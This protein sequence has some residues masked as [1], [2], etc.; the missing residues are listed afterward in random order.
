[1]PSEIGIDIGSYKTV[2][3]SSSSVL[4]EQP[5]VAAVDT[6]TLEPICFGDK[7]YAM[8]DKTPPSIEIVRPIV[9]GVVADYA[10]TEKMLKFFMAEAFSNNIIK[11]KIMVAMPFGVTSVQHR[12]VAKALELSGGRDVRT[13]EAPLADAIALKLNFENPHGYFLIDIG[14][15]TTDIAA[16]SMGG[17]VKSDTVP[18]A[19]FDFDDAIIKYVRK[20]FSV[21]IGHLTAETIKKQIGGAMPRDVSLTMTAS[22]MENFSRKP[23]TFEITSDDI[24]EALSEPLKA[25][26]QA[27]KKVMEKTPPDIIADVAADGI[28]LTGGGALLYG[29]EEYLSKKLGTRVRLCDNP[30]RSAA[31]GTVIALKH[32]QLIKNGDYTYRTI[33]DLI[34]DDEGFGEF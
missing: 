34:V 12:S 2:I 5:T 19:S 17:F 21:N 32:P 9:R 7:A 30:L 10:L 27:I 11:P 8:T 18:M 3:C 16:I 20:K 24:T 14:A 29:M 15:G 33:A 1:M 23:L 26:V 6:Y 13:V 31:K 28:F 25:I 22:G 4:F